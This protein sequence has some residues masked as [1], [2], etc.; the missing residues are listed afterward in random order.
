MASNAYL[1]DIFTRHQIFLERYGGGRTRAILPIL[2]QMA[3]DVNARLQAGESDYMAGRL[4]ALLVDIENLISS[5]AARVERQLVLDLEELS[6]YEAE[7][8]R[9]AYQKATTA[10]FVLPSSDLLA[11]LVT[12][13]QAKLVQGKA[14]KRQTLPQ[15]VATFDKANQKAILQIIRNGAATGANT[16]EITKQISKLVGSRT[17][18]QAEAL[19]RTSTNLIASSARE[20]F[21]K[22]NSKFL[23]KEELV[24]TLD[25]RVTVTC[26]SLDGNKYPIGKGPRPPLHYGCRTIRIAVVPPEYNKPDLDGQR[27]A[28]DGEQN[29]QTTYG[30]WLKRQPAELQDEVLGKDRAALFRAGKV[31]IGD[32]TDKDGVPYSLTELK[33]REGA[34]LS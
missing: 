10:V 7:F 8:A 29:S 17:R 23:Q 4:T 3:V 25:A 15:M 18:Q 6:A 2:R 32:F 5:A 22:R 1:I 11:S 30:G 16:Q 13:R 31:S 12:K 27:R 33:R 21:V 19:A 26:A 28:D 24:A 9:R 34:T 20:E 14:I